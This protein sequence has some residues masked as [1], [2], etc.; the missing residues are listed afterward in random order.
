MQSVTP[1]WWA[2]AACNAYEEMTQAKS[3]G[4]CQPL[5]KDHRHSTC[6]TNICT[7]SDRKM[8]ATNAQ[9]SSRSMLRTQ[10]IIVNTAKIL[11]PTAGEPSGHSLV[12][13]TKGTWLWQYAT[14]L[15]LKNIR[16]NS[17]MNRK[18]TEQGKVNSN[19]S[20]AN[21]YNLNQHKQLRNTRLPSGM[22][23]Y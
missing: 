15:M 16:E 2:L 19:K 4:S 23:A 21:I 10:Y 5:H 8:E 17:C 9:A 20:G 6:L 1:S 7:L 11:L 12:D 22:L 14:A 3:N 13:L 18:V